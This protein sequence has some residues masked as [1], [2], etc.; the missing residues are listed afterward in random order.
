MTGLRIGSFCSGIGGLDLAVEA[1]YRAT[2]AWFCEVEPAPSKV[3]AARWPGVPNHGDLTAADWA[4]V[5]P[6]DIG[7]AGYPCQPFSTAGKRQGT[8]D[9]RHLWPAV[10]DA[11][12]VLR[13]RK[14]VL[15]NVRGHL[16]SGFD[17]VLADLAG[18]GFDA[19]WGVFRSTD[20]GAPHQRARL[21]VVATNTD[22]VGLERR[23]S[24]RRVSELATSERR[25]VDP[26]GDSPTT[27]ADYVG[28]ERAGRTRDR[29]QGSA[30]NDQPATNANETDGFPIDDLHGP[31]GGELHTGRFAD[32]RCTD[33][34]RPGDRQRTNWGKYAAAVGRWEHIIG[35]QAPAPTDANRRLNPDFPEWMMGFPTGWTACGLSRA[36]RLKAIGNSV[37]PQT[38]LLALSELDPQLPSEHL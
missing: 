25:P 3:L 8:E 11:V 28:L 14:L 38:A 35:R 30:N 13:P 31:R 7:T 15:E 6:V 26:A 37:Q 21:F 18:L 36:Q 23:D 24:E 32:R 16:S 4:N 1:H 9:E 20:V 2:T 33:S 34:D 19:E 27:N 10:R 29:R 5:E 17:A 12:G 22:I